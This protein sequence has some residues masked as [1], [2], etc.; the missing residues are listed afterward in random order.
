[1]TKWLKVVWNNTDNIA[2]WAQILALGVAAYWTYTRFLTGEAP[3]LEPRVITRADYAITPGPTEGT[4]H[5]QAHIFVSNDGKT[6]I[7]IDT[8]H[9]QV[10]RSP[11]PAA[12]PDIQTPLDE[13]SLERKENFLSETD[14]RLPTLLH[15]YAPGQQSDQTVS[16][17]IKKQPNQVYLF[18]I[19]VGA[20]DK[21][22]HELSAS[23]R[24]WEWGMCTGSEK[25]PWQP[26]V[27]GTSGGKP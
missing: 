2:K 17:I 5:F 18:K 24:F 6:S 23:T 26:A 16:W 9:L 13:N 11:L 14:L 12:T 3:S 22:G 4:C 8:V 25:T 10:F 21:S 1:M 27:T 19:N 20:K 7:D 15:H